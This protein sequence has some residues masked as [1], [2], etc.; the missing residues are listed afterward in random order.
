MMVRGRAMLRPPPTCHVSASMYTAA[1][2]GASIAGIAS[3]GRACPE[4]DLM[5]KRLSFQES[6]RAAS[7]ASRPT[8]PEAGKHNR[9]AGRRKRT[10]PGG[11][12]RLPCPVQ[13]QNKVSAKKQARMQ[14]IAERLASVDALHSAE[15]AAAPSGSSKAAKKRR[16]KDAA[17]KA[18]LTAVA[19]VE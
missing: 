10:G 2:S 1:P 7:M 4:C 9:K 17:L 3:S 8:K 18:S 6:K 5:E 11:G 13:K 15:E 19:A 12:E 14:Q 16:R